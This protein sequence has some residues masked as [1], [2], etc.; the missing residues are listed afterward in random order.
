[1]AEDFTTI[2]DYFENGWMSGDFD[3]WEA[4]YDKNLTILAGWETF[5]KPVVPTWLQPLTGDIFVLVSN[6][7]DVWMLRLGDVLQLYPGKEYR[8]RVLH[9]M[10]PGGPFGNNSPHLWAQSG[11]TPI[12]TYHDLKKWTLLW[13]RTQLVP[14]DITYSTQF[15]ATVSLPYLEDATMILGQRA[16]YDYAPDI[17]YFISKMRMKFFG[18]GSITN[19]P[20]VTLTEFQVK[21]SSISMYAGGYAAASRFQVAFGKIDG[22]GS[23]ANTDPVYKDGLEINCSNKASN[24]TSWDEFILVQLANAVSPNSSKSYRILTR[25]EYELG[26]PY[27]L[28]YWAYGDAFL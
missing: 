5:T 4:L 23:G 21:R 7:D 11:S 3:E 6:K 14:K 15:W 9:T 1:M 24:E 25:V 28:S 20:T 17:P 2:G 22:S 18:V 13:S 16:V 26:H 12:V 27:D 19:T 10:L 8:I